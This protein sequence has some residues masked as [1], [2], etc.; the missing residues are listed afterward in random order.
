MLQPHLGKLG[1][2]ENVFIAVILATGGGRREKG[3]GGRG[4]GSHTSLPAPILTGG[5]R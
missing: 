4:G 2:F 1:Q 5:T 3:R